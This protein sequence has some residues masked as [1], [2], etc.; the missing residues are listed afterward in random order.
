M[1][2][3]LITC[4]YRYLIIRRI[5]DGDLV[6]WT[7]WRVLDPFRFNLINEFE[8]SL[9]RFMHIHPQLKELKKGEDAILVGE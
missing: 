8:P 6:A 1:Q 4:Y 5:I 3:H 9:I 7:G 2:L